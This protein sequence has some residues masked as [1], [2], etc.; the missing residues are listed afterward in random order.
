M[1]ALTF[2]STSQSVSL[3]VLKGGLPPKEFI[4]IAT[5]ASCGGMFFSIAFCS[6]LG[7]A[8]HK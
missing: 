7:Y 6:V 8:L 5:L 3:E 2:S 1:K 4:H